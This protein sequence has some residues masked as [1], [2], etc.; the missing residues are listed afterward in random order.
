M[1]V[2]AA[3][4]PGPGCTRGRPSGPSRPRVRR[5]RKGGQEAGWA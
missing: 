5:Y 4:A 1:A 3:V 2:V